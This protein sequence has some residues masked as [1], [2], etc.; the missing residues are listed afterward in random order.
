MRSLQQ[1]ICRQSRVDHASLLPDSRPLWATQRSSCRPGSGP[2]DLAVTPI[3]RILHALPQLIPS[4][5]ASW[6]RLLR[7]RVKINRRRS[8]RSDF[9]T[10]VNRHLVWSSQT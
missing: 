2:L 1:H 9:S 6:V 7:Q 8:R 10:P 3:V 4:A 5:G